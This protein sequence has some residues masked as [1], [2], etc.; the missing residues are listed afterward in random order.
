M[1]YVRTVKTASGATAVQIVWST[2]RG[3]RSIEHVGS[4]H[5][6]AELAALKAAAAERLAANQA[7][8]DLE[9]S[10]PAGS[11]PLPITSSQMTHLWEGLCAA[12]RIL[13]FEAVTKGDK[14]FRDLVLARIIE[15][16][17]KV[18]AERVLG[19]VG[20][21]PASYATV[22]RR[23]RT[24][25]T[26][27][28]RQSLAA[29]S[30]RRARL[31]PASLVLFDVSTLYF[32]TDAGDGFREPGFSKERRLEPQITL[33]LLTD[34]SGFPLTVQA[35]EG[36]RA[37]TA[38]MLPVLNAF[39]VA[40]QLTDV[41]VVAD[42]GMI[43]EANQVDLQ[44]AGLSYILGAR[45]PFLPDVVR[46]WCDKHP[47]EAVPDGLVLTQ[48]WPA[49]SS[50]KA[51]GIPDRV[52]YY[53]FRHD[54]ARRSLRGI[55][56]QVAKAQR[57]VEGHAAVKRNRF[58]KLAGAT[59]SVNRELEAKSRALAGWKGYTTNLTKQSA[60]FVIDAYHQLWHVEKAFRM[61]KHDL[62]ARPI[63]H[64]LR[65]SIDAHL[66]IVVAAMAV[67]HYIETQT[68]W[69]IKRFVRTTRR[70]RTV[71]IQAGN[72]TLT[73]ADPLPDDLRVALIKIRA[74]GAH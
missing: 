45:I 21:Q 4:A 32:E 10:A 20:V 72:H 14:V 3:S 40:H 43:S 54:R 13:G 39:K 30:A 49:T 34:G 61:S 53:Q 25:A 29:A 23:L 16:S 41:T 28:W 50:E 55:D 24:Y 71:K 56:E 46:E 42:A 44:A 15:P 9:V 26:S 2:R 58:I 57:A 70:Y 63:Y 1:A 52:T 8:L 67:S 5:N 38:T 6:E 47:D 11:E 65:E 27:A 74:D 7:V 60:E 51:R 12:Y 22:K 64:H 37:E 69:S 33:G 48:P 19:E 59:K 73:A 18:D 66:S 17:S 31:G 62:Q 36:N 35:F 68:G